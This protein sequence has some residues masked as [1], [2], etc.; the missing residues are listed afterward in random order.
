MSNRKAEVDI[1]E[2]SFVRGRGSCWSCWRKV[3]VAAIHTSIVRIT[4]A[5]PLRA[6]RFPSS[7]FLKTFL[8]ELVAKDRLEQGVYHFSD[9]PYFANFLESA[10]AYRN[11]FLTCRDH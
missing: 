5:V 7:S 10:H 3:G 4:I 8:E 2:F 11:S 6:R 9:E 1:I